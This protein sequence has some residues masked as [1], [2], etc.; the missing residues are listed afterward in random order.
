M[1]VLA[2][3]YPV[4]MPWLRPAPTEAPAA[5][6]GAPNI[7]ND[8]NYLNNLTPAQPAPAPAAA[9]WQ[10]PWYGQSAFNPTAPA[11]TPQATFSAPA[12]APTTP[13]PPQSNI[14]S[15]YSGVDPNAAMLSARNASQAAD[16]R[17]VD[18][19]GRVIDA[20]GATQAARR[21][22]LPAQYGVLSARGEVLNAQ[23]TASTFDRAYVQKQQE[24]NAASEQE[25][26]AEINARNNTADQAAIA[27]AKNYRA[28]TDR[29]YGMFGVSAPTDVIN[30]TGETLPPGTR[31]ALR[32]LD[33]IVT[34]KNADT[35]G[36]RKTGLNAARLATSWAQLDVN[37]KQRAASRAG[38]TLDQAEMAVKQAELDETDARLGESRASL[39]SKYAN[40]DEQTAATPP[41]EGAERY[42]DPA[43]GQGMWLTPADAA[44]R[45]QSDQAN[46]SPAKEKPVRE[47]PS[48][49][50]SDTPLGAFS[51]SELTGGIQKGSFSE[52]Q[53]TDELTSRGLTPDQARIKVQQAR[54]TQP[55]PATR[56]SPTQLGAF[57]DASLL[58]FVGVQGAPVN[59]AQVMQELLTRGYTDG[60]AKIMITQEKL[61]KAPTTPQLTVG[62]DGK[63]VAVTR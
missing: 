20:S 26:Q 32:T 51:E 34:E 57:S 49:R 13:Y 40:L 3:T 47:N 37:D 46:L 18:A 29:N 56:Y 52:Q 24:D 6:G 7:W 10:A 11:P 27:E 50:Y 23:D 53:V 4:G 36:A 61:R 33:D 16:R 59:E 8:P 54:Q 35:A 21:G 55:Q 2:P 19:S 45:K 44:I 12:P 42:T 38:L 9:A 58:N 48:T 15:A 28:N 14:S 17:V 22:T 25:R 63:I 62:P 5:T 43:T 30:R 60:Q 31:E 41:F 39:S 1:A